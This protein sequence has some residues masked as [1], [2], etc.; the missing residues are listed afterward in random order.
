MELIDVY[1]LVRVFQFS[2]VIFLGFRQFS[3]FQSSSG[4]LE[5]NFD[6][7]ELNWPSRHVPSRDV[8]SQIDTQL[9]WSSTPSLLYELSH[10]LSFSSPPGCV[11][12]FPH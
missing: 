4:L 2:G 1:F 12:V 5:L 10:L 3:R 6:R 9:E 8:A 11:S 7:F